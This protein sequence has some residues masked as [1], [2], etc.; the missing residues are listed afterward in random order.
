MPPP[1][2]P[3]AP[4]SGYTPPFAPPGRPKRF[5]WFALIASFLVG[6][7]LATI[8]VVAGLV[9][10]GSNLPDSIAGTH[11]E[12]AEGEPAAEVGDCLRAPPEG[13]QVSTK[14]QVVPCGAAH[15]SEVFGVFQAPDADQEPGR[16]TWAEYADGVCPMAYLGY[17]GGDD[18]DVRIRW[19]AVV[20]SAGAW[21]AGDRTVFCLAVSVDH[22]GGVGSVRGVGG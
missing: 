13:A 18:D 6:G 15:G 2:A 9:L 21:E 14:D 4:P 11:N 17:V 20:P 5:G 12:I 1:G 22:E 7:L 3:G 19:K 10:I 16:G 8:V